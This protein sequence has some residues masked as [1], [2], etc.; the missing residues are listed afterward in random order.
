MA[1]YD[2]LTIYHFP[3]INE[4]NGTNGCTQLCVNQPGSF[5]CACYPGYE[6]VSQTQC[7]GMWMSYFESDL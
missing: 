4:C 6:L 1:Y 7:R 3:D 2:N 5:E